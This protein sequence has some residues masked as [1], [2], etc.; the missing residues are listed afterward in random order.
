M[1][2]VKAIGNNYTLIEGRNES[3]KDS[4]GSYRAKRLNVEDQEGKLKIK[5]NELHM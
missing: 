4:V 5:L 1:D 3:I 2:I